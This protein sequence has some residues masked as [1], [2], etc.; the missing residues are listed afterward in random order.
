ML[1]AEEA[2]IEDILYGYGDEGWLDGDDDEDMLTDEEVQDA[3]LECGLTTRELMD[4][5]SRDITTDD[6]DTLLK[7]DDRVPPKTAK[8]EF[9]TNL[10]VLSRAEVMALVTASGPPEKC[11]PLPT[12]GSS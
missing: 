6:Y 10:R 2:Y 3:E 7:L 9:I 4:I 11:M 8:A 1:R 12:L 5:L